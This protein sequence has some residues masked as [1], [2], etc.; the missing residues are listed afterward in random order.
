MDYFF[1]WLLAVTFLMPNVHLVAQEHDQNALI[2]ITLEKVNRFKTNNQNDSALYELLTTARLLKE[3]GAQSGYI[4]VEVGN[5]YFHLKLYTTA[6]KFYGRANVIF[7]KHSDL[8]GQAIILENYGGIHDRLNKYDSALFYYQKALRLQQKTGDTFYAAH[9]QRAIALNYSLMGKQEEAKKFIHLALQSIQDSE[10][11]NHPRYAWDV[12]F[13]PQQVFLSA[14]DIF[15]N[16]KK[17][18]SA[19][20]NLKEAIRMTKVHGIEAHRVRYTTF[21]ATFY[22]E[23]KQ[24]SKAFETIQQALSLADSVAYVWGKVGALQVL[25]NYYHQT[26]DTK[27]ELEAGYDYLLY[28]DKMYNEQNNDELIVMSNLVLQYENELEI[29]R[30][31]S[32][33]KEQAQINQLQ[34]RENYLLLGL[35]AIFLIALISVVYLYRY[36]QHKT[37]LVQQYSDDL[38]I[39]NETMRMLLSVI[40]HDLRSPF[41]SLMGLTKVTLMEEQLSAPELRERVTMM[42]D[43]ASKGSILLDNLLQWVALQRDK[44]LI[45]KETVEVSAVV[46]E[47]I[48]ELA[49]LALTQNATIER[50]I[51]L[52]TY[53]TDKNA[54]KVIIRNMLT[55]AIK[56]SKGL[57][58]ILSIKE[59]DSFVFIHVTDQGPGIPEELLQT[60]FVQGD[61]K[62]VAAKGGGLGMMIVKDFVTQLNGQIRALN[63]PEGGARFEVRLPLH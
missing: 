7:L 10:I 62:K 29:G 33:V 8:I 50:N 63:L 30:Q 35:L 15:R 4:Y 59:V 25:R 16:E 57:K 20:F 60:L 5:V 58:V 53:H 27:K 23:Q 48:H 12:Q 51:F 11:V 1:R 2:N 31:Q 14:S 34:Q 6:K 32:L 28:K 24:Y 40:S 13:I 36:L 3:D 47:T 55:N 61:M 46:E 22:L 43:T 26:K 56:Y 21:L 17:F 39:N 19:E 41:H 18:D 54:L 49:N 9:S 37:K 38:K 52:Q 44:V 42:H 45:K